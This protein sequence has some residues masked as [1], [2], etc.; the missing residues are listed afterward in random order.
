MFDNLFGYVVIKRDFLC[1]IKKF[2][3]IAYLAVFVDEAH[4]HFVVFDLRALAGYVVDGLALDDN[5][6]V[7]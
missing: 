5:G 2:A 7:I 1:D 4:E 3:R 6:V